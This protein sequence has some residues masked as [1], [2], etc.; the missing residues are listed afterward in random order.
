MPDLAA[1]GGKYALFV[2]GAYGASLA[3][4]VWMVVDTLVRAR[5]AKR[6]VERL[7]GGAATEPGA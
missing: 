2:W 4:F 6:A 1:A 7:E 5:A 3:A